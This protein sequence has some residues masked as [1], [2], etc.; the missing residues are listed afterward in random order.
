M[1]N[2]I[3]P[4][5][6]PSLLQTKA[7]IQYEILMENISDIESDLSDDEEIVL[8]LASFGQ[9]ITMQVTDIGYHGELLLFTGYVD[10]NP[11]TLFQHYTQISFLVIVMPREKPGQ[12]PRRIGYGAD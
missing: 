2:I 7:E 8:K 1:P 12:P 9:T 4:D 3:D 10:N 5:K 11:S 6:F